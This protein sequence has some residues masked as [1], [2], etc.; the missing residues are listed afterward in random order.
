MIWQ[1]VSSSH[2]SHGAGI[3]RHRATACVGRGFLR[4]VKKEFTSKPGPSVHRG[5]VLCGIAPYRPYVS[6]CKHRKPVL[7]T[8]HNLGQARA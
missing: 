1:Q 6:V 7:R 5:P 3:C 8:R 2:R 4:M